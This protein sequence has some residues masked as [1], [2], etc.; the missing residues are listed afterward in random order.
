MDNR[1]QKTKALPILLLIFIILCLNFVSNQSKININRRNS[2][3]YENSLINSGYRYKDDLSYKKSI[4]SIMKKYSLEDLDFLMGPEELAYYIKKYND[5]YSYYAYG[6]FNPPNNFHIENKNFRANLNVHSTIS[7]GNVNIKDILDQA[8][9]YADVLA[10]SFPNEKYIIAI[11]DINSVD[12][13]KTILETIKADPEKYKNIRVVFGIEIP[14]TL[15]YNSTIKDSTDI[16]LLVYCINPFD[17][18]I[19]NEFPPLGVFDNYDSSRKDFDEIVK[20]L[21]K[22]KYVIYGIAKPMEAVSNANSKEEFIDNLLAYYTKGY[23]KLRFAEAY[24]DPYTYNYFPE[25][26]YL[27][28]KLNSMGI[29]KVGSIDQFEDKIFRYY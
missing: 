12:G 27:L 10:E 7:D 9:Q 20:F 16:N 22:Q 18:N 2:A 11:T 24:Y 21:G 4:L 29:Y 19:L 23:D 13:A 8:A 1:H 25:Y 6:Q 28:E 5:D 15:E 14:T 3:K 17:K 26:N